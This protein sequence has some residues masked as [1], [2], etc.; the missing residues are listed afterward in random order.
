LCMY[1][2]ASITANPAS[3]KRFPMHMGLQ[4]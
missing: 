1:G 4:L 3:V 2:F